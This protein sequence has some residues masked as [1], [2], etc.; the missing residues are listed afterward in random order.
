MRI[1]V[2]EET[3]R[4]T[5]Q[6]RIKVEHEGTQGIVMVAKDG[7][8]Y[9]NT[10]GE[11]T[12]KGDQWHAEGS[13]GNQVRLSLNSPLRMTRDEWEKLRD[14]IDEELSDLLD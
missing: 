4:G 3:K 11:D 5:Y 12:R 10:F 6:R 8:E 2:F 13:R 1:E 14:A 9:G 7:W